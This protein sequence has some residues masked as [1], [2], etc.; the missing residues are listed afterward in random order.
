MIV[1]K[2][3]ENPNDVNQIQSLLAGTLLL[4][5]MV[6]RDDKGP[7]HVLKFSLVNDSCILD[8]WENGISLNN[9]LVSHTHICCF[10]L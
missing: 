8:S 2:T 9:F 7:S 1:T 5:E 10:L 6:A 3:S 4:Y